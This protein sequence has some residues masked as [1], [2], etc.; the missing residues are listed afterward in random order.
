MARK[1]TESIKNTI[2]EAVQAIDLSP[3]EPDSQSNAM[4]HAA[5]C[6]AVLSAARE[7]Q[8]LSI[9]EIATRLRLSVKQI[10]ALEADHFTSLP[11]PT[12]VRGFIR[13]YAK[14]LK[15]AAEP[16]LEAYSKM[17]PSSMPHEMIVKPSANMKMTS[18]K[19]PKT[20]LY[21]LAALVVLLGLG[22]WFFYQNYVQKPSPTKEITNIGNIESANV[23]AVPLP[24]PEPALPMAER[25]AA[26]QASTELTLPPPQEPTT[27]NTVQPEGEVAAVNTILPATSAPV[28]MKTPATPVASI[29]MPTMP[30]PV[31]ASAVGMGRLEFSATQETWVN[32]IDGNGQEVYSK[33]IFAGSRETINA[34]LPVDITVG[35]AGATNLSMNGKSYDLAPYSRNNVA[36]I[37]L[38]K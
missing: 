12:I 37:K 4:S 3:I 38:E 2:Q 31:V 30:E 6:G 29:P 36:H 25:E 19:K 24:L 22:I 35:N 11:E 17:V 15:I 20:G 33:T 28:D 26:L 14:Q 23:E 13:N 27:P 5:K 8:N 16:L 10:E 32:V 34:K 21:G 18:Y 7:E 1:I 9:Q